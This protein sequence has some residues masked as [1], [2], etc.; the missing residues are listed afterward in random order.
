MYKIRWDCGDAFESLYNYIVTGTPLR[1]LQ[2][3]LRAS[4]LISCRKI[5]VQ[6]GDVN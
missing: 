2:L 5:Y 1:G 3:L 6:G 4:A